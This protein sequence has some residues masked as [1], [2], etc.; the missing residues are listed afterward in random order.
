[1][2]KMPCKRVS[3]FIG[4]L[5]GKLEGVRLPGFLREKKS[6]SG[7]FSRTQRTLRY[8]VWGP[9]G[10]SVKEQGSIELI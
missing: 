7:F 9:S 2:C 1:M 6:I 4:D 8:E 10:T 3:L 5:L